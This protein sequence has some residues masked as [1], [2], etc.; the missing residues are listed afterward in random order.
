MLPVL[1]K[2]LGVLCILWGVIALFTPFTPGA[3][4]IFIGM[5]LLGMGFLLP[6]RFR[7]SAKRIKDKIQSKFKKKPAPTQEA[8]SSETT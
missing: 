7:G 1:K 4:L 5:E 3:W 6:E 8:G 2:I